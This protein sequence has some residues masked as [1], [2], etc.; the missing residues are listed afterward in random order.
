[1][2]RTSLWLV[3]AALFLLAAVAGVV[4]TITNDGSWTLIAIPL[5]LLA[6]SIVLYSLARR[7]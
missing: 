2:S 4:N 6:M 5:G 7:Q 3:G 1:M